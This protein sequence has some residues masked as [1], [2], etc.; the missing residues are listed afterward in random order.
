MSCRPRP[1]FLLLLL[2]LLLPAPG[3]ALDIHIYRDISHCVPG[4]TAP[5]GAATA[6]SQHAS[7]TC[8][9]PEGEDKPAY[10]L[11]CVSGNVVQTAFNKSDCSDVPG[12]VVLETP[13]DV[14]THYPEGNTSSFYD[15]SRAG[16]R[17][18]APGGGAAAGWV[19]VLL[20]VAVLVNPQPAGAIEVQFY[21]DSIDCTGMMTV[22]ETMPSNVCQEVDPERVD[23][24]GKAAAV[25]GE[26]FECREG[27]VWITEYEDEECKIKSAAQP[28]FSLEADRCTSFGCEDA[29]DRS[30]SNTDQSKTHGWVDGS[31]VIYDCSGAWRRGAPV[32]VGVAVAT[33]AVGLFL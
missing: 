33:V 14:C 23:P 32:L 11:S 9:A 25:R 4:H 13:G 6:T 22:K 30:T 7:N 24:T 29:S 17:R 26:M 10:V 1:P 16:P 3:Y 12:T 27:R 5:S 21:K 28:K 2:L 31:S 20:V 8:E 18:R 19:M 15:C